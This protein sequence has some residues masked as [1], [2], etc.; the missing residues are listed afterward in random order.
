MVKIAVKN[1]TI[2]AYT[3]TKPK[4]NTVCSKTHFMK[5]PNIM[6]TDKIRLIFPKRM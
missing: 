3:Q 5:R 2:T 6:F 1:I 4:T